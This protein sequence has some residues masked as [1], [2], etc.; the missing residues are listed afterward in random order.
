MKPKDTPAPTPG[1]DALLLCDMCGERYRS[2]LVVVR[3]MELTQICQCCFVELMI[4]QPL[5][6]N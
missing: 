1:G 5:L 4:A 6:L 2:A 3:G